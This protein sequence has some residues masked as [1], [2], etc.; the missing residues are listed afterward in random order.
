MDSFNKSKSY[1]QLPM[2]Q[3]HM[4]LTTK[5]LTKN[6]SSLRTNSQN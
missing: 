1:N 5:G 4:D 6:D 2:L 3:P